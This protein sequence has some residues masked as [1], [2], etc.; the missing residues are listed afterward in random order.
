MTTSHT[1][2]LEPIS[3]DNPGGTDVSFSEAY[4]EIREARRQDDPSL[5]QGEWE[6]SLKVA[7]WPRVKALSEGDSLGA[8]Q[9]H[10]GRRLVYRS[11][12]TPQRLRQ[13]WQ[14][15]CRCS[16]ASERLLGVRLS[17]LRSDDLEE[18]AGKIEWLNKQMLFVI[19][20]IPLTPSTSGGYSWLKWEESRAVENLGLKDA[21]ARERAVAGG[22]LAGDV[23]DRAVQSSGV[24]TTKPCTRISGVLPRSAL[25]WNSTSTNASAAT[26]PASR[27]CARR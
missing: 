6:T 10:P 5:A 21:E 17:R 7:Q 19:R 27:T 23:F 11:H 26:P 18:R 9:G 24:P 8:E 16:T 2:L 13:V 3:G 1:H 4:D 25:R 12:G 22:K 15:V 14:R 20:D